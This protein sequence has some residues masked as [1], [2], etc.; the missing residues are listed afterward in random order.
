MTDLKKKFTVNRDDEK[1]FKRVFKNGEELITKVN[2]WQKVIDLRMVVLG[3]RLNM[4]APK[5][6]NGL[7]QVM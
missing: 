4:K 3:W 2:K 7:L 5:N 6:R 1:T